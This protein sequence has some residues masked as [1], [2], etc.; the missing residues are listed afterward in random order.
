MSVTDLRRE[1]GISRG[2]AAAIDRGEFTEEDFAELFKM[3]ENGV[4]EGIYLVEFNALR[5]FL[6]N[7]HELVMAD[8]RLMV[9]IDPNAYLDGETDQ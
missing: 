5:R 1:F 9:F 3:D 7:N 6:L 4:G 8:S 2:I